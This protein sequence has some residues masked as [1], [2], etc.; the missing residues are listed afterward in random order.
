MPI[1]MAHITISLAN[2][3][4]DTIIAAYQQVAAGGVVPK[5]EQIVAIGETDGHLLTPFN[6]NDSIAFGG[7][8]M[9]CYNPSFGYLLEKLPLKSLHIGSIYEQT[10]GE[11]N[12][13]NP[14]CYV[15]PT[16][17]HCEPGAHFSVGEKSQAEAFAQY[18]PF[19]F[20]ISRQQK[21]ANLITQFALLIVAGFLGFTAV[22]Y[23]NQITRRYIKFR[24]T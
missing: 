24:Q 18:K 13:K 8:Q 4:P 23:L 5:I 10:K 16:E 22:F 14:A 12:I 3:R 21:I 15:F 9:Q 11:L 6:P 7:S 20:A 1:N 19:S 2:Y 17:N